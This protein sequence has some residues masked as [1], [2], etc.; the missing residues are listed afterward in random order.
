[1]QQLSENK[2]WFITGADGGLGVDI[3]RAEPSH[4]HV[5]RP[6]NAGR[7]RRARTVPSGAGWWRDTLRTAG[8]VAGLGAAGVLILLL[9]VDMLLLAATWVRFEGPTPVALL[10]LAGAVL[11]G[12]ACLSV[13]TRI[14]R[15][16]P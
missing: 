6:L 16:Q 7:A 9:W 2:A 15:T 8:R 3:A 13:L 12:P 10:L 5:P 1:V 11:L 4:I 14:D